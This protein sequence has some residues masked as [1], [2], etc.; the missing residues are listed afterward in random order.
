LGFRPDQLPTG[1]R[2][3]P[4]GPE[5]DPMG[6]AA[7]GRTPAPGLELPRPMELAPQRRILCLTGT[8]QSG[9]PTSQSPIGQLRAQERRPSGSPTPGERGPAI[10]KPDLAKAEERPSNQGQV[11]RLAGGDER[12]ARKQQSP[13]DPSE[14]SCGLQRLTTEQPYSLAHW[15]THDSR[16]GRPLGTLPESRRRRGHGLVPGIRIE[17]K[18]LT[19][20]VQE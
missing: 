12:E 15:V 11:G 6:V 10:A 19:G 13:R 7:L 14:A 16:G 9:T 2:S 5:L 4:G 1:S 8:P 20:L 18:Q 3:R 17:V